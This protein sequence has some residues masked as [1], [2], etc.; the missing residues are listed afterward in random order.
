MKKERFTDEKSAENELSKINQQISVEK[1]LLFCPLMQGRCV[2]HN[3]VSW[4]KPVMQHFKNKDPEVWYINEQYCGCNNPMI[5]GE[6]RVN[7]D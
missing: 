2:G 4:D 3:C 5:N 6:I 7:R 1:Q